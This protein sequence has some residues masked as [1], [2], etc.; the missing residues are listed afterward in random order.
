MAPFDSILIEQ[1][2]INLLENA[3]KYTPDGTTIEI[4]A[5]AVDGAIEVSVSDRGPG[6]PPADAEKVFEKFYRAGAGEG[7]GGVGLGLTICRGVITAHGGR[8][9]VDARPG[10]GAAF[11]FTIPLDGPPPKVRVDE[12]PVSAE[13]ATA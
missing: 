5:R 11:R 4:S 6:V 9:W 13:G 7:R 2:L 12:E 1:V 3:L 10:G 8:L